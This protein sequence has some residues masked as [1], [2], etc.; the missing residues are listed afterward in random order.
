TAP[1]TAPTTGPTGWQPPKSM[2]WTSQSTTSV[3]FPSLVAVADAVSEATGVAIKVV[4][5]GTGLDRAATMRAKESITEFANAADAFCWQTGELDL[6][7]DGWGPQIGRELW[8]GGP[9]SQGFVTQA[10]SGIKT[11]QD[12]RGRKVTSYPSYPLVQRYHDSFL[13]FGGLTWED[14]KPIPFA[15]A[16]QAWSALVAGTVECGFLSQESASAYELEASPHGIYWIPFPASDTEG[17][18]RL[19]GQCPFFFPLTVTT[20]PGASPANPVEIYGYVFQEIAY[21]SMDD[22]LAY[23]LVKTKTENYDK[24]K[25]KHVYS[26]TFTLENAV[27]VDRA[28]LPFH[29]GAI[30]Y[31]KEVGVWGAKEDAWQAKKLA[32]EQQFIAAWKTQHP[33]W[34]WQGTA[35]Q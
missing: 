2:N 29:P 28:S 12:I 20:G 14:V 22:N 3:G 23:W 33:D 24:F 31:Y 19:Q 5:A 11:I 35:N 7:L 17:W 18:K 8:L 13:A 34:K 1:T 32:E 25:D 27:K 9:F 26:A 15:S 10:D 4:A 16:G 6:E 21:A 30:K